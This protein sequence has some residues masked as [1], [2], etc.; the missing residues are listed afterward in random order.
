MSF[1]GSNKR[2]TMHHRPL[3]AARATEVSDGSCSFRR[4]TT[5]TYVVQRTKENDV[6]CVEEQAKEEFAVIVPEI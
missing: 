4:Y 6:L 3:C 5:I 2:Y 1:I